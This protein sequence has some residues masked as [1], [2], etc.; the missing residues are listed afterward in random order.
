M[1]FECLFTLCTT[2]PPFNSRIFY[3]FLALQF[4]RT[5]ELFHVCTLQHISCS[6]VH[7]YVWTFPRFGPYESSI[8]YPLKFISH[9]ILIMKMNS[10]VHM[11]RHIFL[12]LLYP[13]VH[14]LMWFYFAPSNT[15]VIVRSYE[16]WR[17]FYFFVYIRFLKKLIMTKT[18]RPTRETHLSYTT[19][20]PI[21]GAATRQLLILHGKA[22]RAS[23]PPTTWSLLQVPVV[24]RLLST[25]AAS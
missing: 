1:N 3:F 15:G 22:P 20:R 25:Y 19:F 7:T 8:S 13:I 11:C 6:E 21:A 2:F 4:I 18:F 9:I 16:L 12:S 14:A 17:T 24:R 10:I 5:Y 23:T